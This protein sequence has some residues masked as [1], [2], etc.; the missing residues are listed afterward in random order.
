MAKLAKK[1]ERTF[2]PIAQKLIDAVSSPA[3]LPSKGLMSDDARE[4]PDLPLMA[5]HPYIDTG[6]LSQRHAD[7]AERLTRQ[8]RYG[9]TPTEERET[10]EFISRV[11]SAT[12]LSL[13]HSNLMRSCRDLLFQVEDKLVDEIRKAH[14]KRPI[15]DKHAIARFEANITEIIRTAIRRESIPLDNL[16]YNHNSEDV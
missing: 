5:A 8:M 6:E 13:T 11:S 16:I 7:M 1:E 3:Q 14:L 9:A 10:K 4:K 15:N 12:G 2:S